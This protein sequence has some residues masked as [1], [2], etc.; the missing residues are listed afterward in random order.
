MTSAALFFGAHPDDVELTSGGLAAMLAAHG[1]RVIVVDL[2]RGEMASRGT[3]DERNAEAAEAARVLGVASREN[4]GLADLG[5]DRSSRPQ[6]D[7]VVD[8]L[9]RHRPSLVVAPDVAD[10]HPD[11]IEAH[12]LI[13]RACYVAGLARFAAGSGRHRP[14]QL[15]FALYRSGRR[16]DLI[17]DVSAAWES[18]MLALR[19]HRSQLAGTPGVETYLTR[20]GFLEEVEARARAFGAAIGAAYGEG[21][22]TAGPL[23]VHD[24]RALLADAPHGGTP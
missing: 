12:H 16:A 15:L 4:L 23:A 6:L 8:C 24:A 18:R 21:Y 14:R 22:R 13:R 5:I 10:D 7:A 17:V 11:H 2:T 1:H 9:R 20:P 3:V 19:A